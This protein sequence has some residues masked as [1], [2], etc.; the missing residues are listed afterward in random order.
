MLTCYEHGR[1][2]WFFRGP[3]I[4][5]ILWP[6]DQLSTFTKASGLS[7]RGAQST[8]NV[9]ADAWVTHPESWR[10]TVK[11]DSMVIGPGMVLSLIWW[12][13]EQQILDLD[14]ENEDA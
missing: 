10:Y 11:E 5:T 1:R 3:D 14:E 2:K 7:T 6:H 4:P 8:A 9:S 12:Q 13:N